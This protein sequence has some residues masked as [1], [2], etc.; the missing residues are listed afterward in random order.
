MIK[1]QK[2]SYIN[3]CNKISLSIDISENVPIEKDYSILS[4]FS[5]IKKILSF[6]NIK[7]VKFLYFNRKKIEGILY[8]E[9]EI[10]F[11]DSNCIEMNLSNYFY[12]SLLVADNANISNYVYKIDLINEI[13]ELNKKNNKNLKNI[14]ISKI[15][16]D[17]INNYSETEDFEESLSNDLVQQN[18]KILAELKIIREENLNI[19]ERIINEFNQNFNFEIEVIKSEKIDKVYLYIIKS[20]IKRKKFEEY[21]YT[22]KILSQLDLENIHLTKIMLDDL[23]NLFDSNEEFILKYKITEVKELFNNSIINFYFLLFKYIIKDSIYIY[24]I[25]YLNKLKTK[26]IKFV[27]N[28]EKIFAPIDKEKLDYIIKIF[29]DSKYYYK[30]FIKKFDFK[31]EKNKSDIIE[32]RL[33]NF[34]EKIL[35]KSSFI[36]KKDENGEINLNILEEK[37][38][39]NRIKKLK[40]NNDFNILEKNL[41]IFLEFLSFVKE[42]IKKEFKYK[43]NLLIKLTFDLKEEN[44]SLFNISCIYKF[45]PINRGET[46]SFIDNNVLDSYIREN[47]EGLYYLLYEINDEKYKNILFQKDLNIFKIMKEKDDLEKKLEENKEMETEENT[48]PLSELCKLSEASEYEIIK[49]IKKM[50]KHKYYAEFIKQLSNGYFISGGAC[51]YLYIYDKNFKKIKDIYIHTYPINVYEKEYNKNSNY[52]ILISYSKEKINIITLDFN[53][54]CN[55]SVD[56]VLGISA[57]ILFEIKDNYF[58]NNTIGGYFVDYF[59]KNFQKVLNSSYKVGLK[60]NDKIIALTSNEIIPKGKNEIILY[61]AFSNKIEREIEGFSCSIRQNSLLLIQSS[62]NNDNILICAC[63]EYK[64]NQN[65]GILLLQIKSNYEIKDLFYNTDKFEPFCICN[66]LIISK[67][68]NS[69]T[70]DVK[71]YK[72]NYF[73][74]G[75][76]D[77]EKGEGKI[78]LFKIIYKYKN[79]NNIKVQFIQ[80]IILKNNKKENFY[81]F[82][83]A[84]T[85]I[86]QSKETGNFLITSNDGNVYE[87]SPHNLS[88]YL[89][90]DEEIKNGND[91]YDINYFYQNINITQKNDNKKM[92][93]EL[94]E[95][96]K[97]KI[98]FL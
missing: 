50:G 84:I 91:Y 66:I 42:K 74:V 19:I 67:S 4:E 59:F 81:G 47:F 37:G 93:N 89:Y 64:T 21:E 34:I 5:E 10:I 56:D 82:K 46:L 57:S 24:H 88:Y 78:K 71:Q 43:Y 3:K 27:K 86:I 83:G 62:I 38:K 26:I 9:E 63:K 29:L 36:L 2:N 35:S 18:N 95:I 76:L 60:I 68:S 25:T 94:L 33:K 6:K 41:Q 23:S 15:I 13:N 30:L 32:N 7:T 65:N 96:Y 61:N 51:K 8:D 53:Q 44:N 17:L 20:L 28:D 1:K 55:C 12:L 48:I 58:I 49:F 70:N 98:S 92:F 87:F 72:T 85:C 39:E 14:M 97:N 77:N 80:D 75:G 16:I 69:K 54:E 40:Y 11:I 31:E 79:N 22:D 73:F 45:Y 90:Y 52:L